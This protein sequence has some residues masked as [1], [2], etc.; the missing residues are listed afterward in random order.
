MSGNG[1]SAMP[2][3]Y[4]FGSKCKWIKGMGKDKNSNAI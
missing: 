4:Y 1:V 3:R 2:I